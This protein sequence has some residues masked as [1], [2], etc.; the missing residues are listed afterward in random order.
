[1]CGCICRRTN[2]Q[3]YKPCLCRYMSM[4][5][6]IYIHIH[7]QSHICMFMCTYTYMGMCIYMYILHAHV[8]CAGRNSLSRGPHVGFVVFDFSSCSFCERFRV[9][10]VGSPLVGSPSTSEGISIKATALS[11]RS[12]QTLWGSVGHNRV[13]GCDRLGVCVPT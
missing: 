7:I 5:A 12:G 2:M 1:M 4:Y 13:P 9:V 10:R 3:V 8:P 11:P 6:Y